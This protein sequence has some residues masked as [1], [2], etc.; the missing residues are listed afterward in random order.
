MRFG[1]GGGADGSGCCRVPAGDAV[2]TQAFPLR[3]AVSF[4]FRDEAASRDYIVPAPPVL[5]KVPYDVFY[6]FLNSAPSGR[7][8][9]LVTFGSLGVSVGLLASLLCAT[10]LIM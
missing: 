8:Q 5:F 6:P 4:V 10:W 9:L 2:S 7:G 1:G 3:I